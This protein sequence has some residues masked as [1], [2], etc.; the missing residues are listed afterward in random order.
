MYLIEIKKM[1]GIVMFNI[2]FYRIS[3]NVRSIWVV[4]GTHELKFSL[5]PKR[6]FD[7]FFLKP[8]LFHES[9]T[10]VQSEFVGRTISFKV[11]TVWSGSICI[12]PT[13][14]QIIRRIYIENA[15]QLSSDFWKFFFGTNVF[16]QVK[17]NGAISICHSDQVSVL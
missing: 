3:A 17:N 13:I 12:L 5:A 7:F 4:G 16:Q 9:R 15:V 2:M 8:M 10:M 1:F 11:I 6:F 14:T